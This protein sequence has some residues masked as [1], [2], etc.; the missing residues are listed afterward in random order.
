MSLFKEELLLGDA[1][2]EIPDER[3]TLRR[4]RLVVGEGVEAVEED[5]V[6]PHLLLSLRAHNLRLREVKEVNKRSEHS[7]FSFI[8]LASSR[9][10]GCSAKI[11]L[12][13]SSLLLSACETNMLDVVV[14]IVVDYLFLTCCE[15]A[16]WKRNAKTTLAPNPQ[17]SITSSGWFCQ[18]KII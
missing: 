4:Q 14:V 12:L 10:A 9:Q 17:S 13:L 6:V 7:E 1:E 18:N 8:C 2:L 16:K 15:L 5:P 3:L 11:F